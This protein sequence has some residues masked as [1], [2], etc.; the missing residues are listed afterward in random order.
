MGFLSSSS[1]GE[2]GGASSAKR[3]VVPP[4]EFG[5]GYA[6]LPD[7]RTVKP[8]EAV[9]GLVAAGSKTR[10]ER[11]ACHES[12]AIE[13]PLPDAHS[14]SHAARSQKDE[15]RSEVSSPETAPMLLP[16]R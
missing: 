2:M 10:S 1:A 5:P 11:P 4:G 9:L 8:A 15:S 7:T 12:V 6:G 13:L 14:F 16:G 3:Q